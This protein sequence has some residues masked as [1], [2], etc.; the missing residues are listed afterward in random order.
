MRSITWVNC[1]RM[2]PGSATWPGH[3]TMSGVRVPPEPGVALPE[4]VRGVAGPGP[5]PRV[6]VVGAEAAPI[7]VGRQVVRHGLAQVGGEAV[8]VDAAVLAALGA[9]PVVGEDH[10]QCV[11]Q[12]AGRLEGVQEAADLRIGMGQEAGE[13]LLLARVHAALVCAE[14]VPALDPLG[15][16]GEDGARRDDAPLRP[17]GR[18]SPG[19]RRPSRGRTSPGTAPPIRGPRGAASAWRPARSTGRTACRA[20]PAAGRAPC[21]WPGPPGPRSGGSPPRAGGAAPCSGCRTPGWAPSGWR[22][23]G[24]TRSGVR[25]PPRGATCRRARRPSAASVG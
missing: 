22:R 7:V 24:G 21:G 4:L 17:G 5:G 1:E 9:G 6:V 25:I 3:C 23:P 8:L 15:P 19:A 18:R 11:L 20:P 12:E 2:A 14:V 10:D 16:L 13:H